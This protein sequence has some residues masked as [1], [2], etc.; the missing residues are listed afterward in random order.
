M[1]EP[2]AGRV[3]RDRGMKKVE[4]A[5]TGWMARALQLLPEMKA[6][7][8]VATGELMRE[9]LTTTA[10]LPNPTHPNAWGTLTAR[11]AKA[12]LIVDTGTMTQMRNKES[13]ARRT[14][15]WRFA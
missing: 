8:K 2:N 6:T 1:F 11:A 3:E 14:P 7:A 5:N 10:G 4:S 12:G 13:H 9:W 15:V